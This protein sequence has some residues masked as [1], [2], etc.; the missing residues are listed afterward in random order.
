[1]KRISAITAILIIIVILLSACSSQSKGETAIN[2]IVKYCNQERAK[3]GLPEI[4][5][6]RDLCDAAQLR[7]GE[8]AT[9]GNFAHIRPDGSGCFTALKT[10][11]NYA[12]ENLAKGEPDGR[13][14]V[15][16]WMDS[17]PHRKNVLTPEYAKT[18]I[19]YTEVDGVYYW[20]ALFTD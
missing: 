8:I 6:D 13:K 9:D 7:A 18:G 3:A 1:M 12:G 20:A 2:D 10:D 4:T 5:L 15:Q 19:A 11:Y 16:A 14:I 17:E